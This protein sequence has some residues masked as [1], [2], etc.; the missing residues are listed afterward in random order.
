MTSASTG[1]R[2]R[3]LRN[4]TAKRQGEGGAADK[5][6]PFLTTNQHISSQLSLLDL[7]SH[8][9]KS[10]CR[11]DGGGS[12]CGAAS[13]QSVVIRIPETDGRRKHSARR[14]RLAEQQSL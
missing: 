8:H 2:S 7:S 6:F 1:R 12:M 5:S 13:V 4:H 14:P 10:V 3:A 9:S 11:R